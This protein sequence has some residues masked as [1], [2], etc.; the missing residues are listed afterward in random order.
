MIEF[1]SDANK[2]FT[3]F[4]VAILLSS[5]NTFGVIDFGAPINNGDNIVL[6]NNVSVL[7]F[8][9]IL[10]LVGNSIIEAPVVLKVKFP[11]PLISKSPPKIIFLFPLF[12]PVPPCDPNK[13]PEIEVA[14][15]A[16]TDL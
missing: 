5:L 8:V 1:E 2:I 6:L 12:I 7:L 14:E 9:T 10:P 11:V 3:K 15:S 4:V 16:T 13:I